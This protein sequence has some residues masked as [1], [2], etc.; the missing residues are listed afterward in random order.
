MIID[1]SAPDFLDEVDGLHPD[2]FA[3]PAIS[4]QLLENQMPL[5]NAMR[6]RRSVN[7]MCTVLVNNGFH[8]AVDEFKGLGNNTLQRFEVLR[9]FILAKI[10]AFNGNIHD[11]DEAILLRIFHLIQ[12]WGGIAGRGI[13]VRNCGFQMNFHIDHYRTLVESVYQ[14]DGGPEEVACSV[15]AAR[16]AAANISCFGIAF[17]SKH[18]SFW[19]Y[20]GPLHFP[21]LDRILAQGVL[22]VKNPHFNRYTVYTQQ[23]NACSDA[24]GITS[25]EL[26]QHCFDFFQTPNGKKWLELRNNAG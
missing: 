25:Q 26:E 11:A 12:L 23:M 24:M 7:G 13:Y 17:A 10:A 15:S 8:S 9:S 16:S 22:G 14:R 2:D 18:M 5:E 21:I 4:D 19:S 3:V 20:S 1:T 6:I